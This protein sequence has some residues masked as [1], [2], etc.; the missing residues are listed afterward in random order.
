MFTTRPELIGNVG[1]V[2]TTHWLASAAGMGILERGGNAADAAA[3][4]GF[5]L[6]VVEPHL[7]GPGGEVPVLVWS[8]RDQKVSTICG[9]GVAPAAATVERL[10]SLGLDLMP[11][12]GL[13]PTVV[14]GAFGAW[15]LLLEEHG[16]L[17]LRAVL[18]PAIHYL[19]QGHPVLASVSEALASVRS[20]FEREWP[21]SA[22]TWLPNGEVPQA[23]YCFTNPVMARTYRRIIEEAE[24]VGGDRVSQ[25]RAAR[26]SWYRGFVAEAVEEFCRT[27]EV[28]DTSGAPHSGL[29]TADDLARWEPTIEDPLSCSSRSACCWSACRF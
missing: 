29:L 8:E 3:A 17:P 25:L 12:T 26:D 28:M 7:N 11:G 22:A 2:A 23:G 4:A 16:S 19:E 13:L 18:E 9:Q 24:S 1:M 10:S 21:T 14:P 20:M 15:T 5:V 27:A 6:Q